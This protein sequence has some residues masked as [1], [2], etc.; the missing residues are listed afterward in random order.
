[1]K[2]RDYL[3]GIENCP[4][5]ELTNKF[6]VYDN[7]PT[8]LNADFD[9]VINYLKNSKEYN[10]TGGF[11]EESGDEL[12]RCKGVNIYKKGN[13]IFIDKK[14]QKHFFNYASGT[15]NLQVLNRIPLNS[16]NGSDEDIWNQKSDYKMMIRLH[17]YKKN[18]I[19]GISTLRA[20]AIVIGGFGKFILNENIPACMPNT[21][22]WD[23]LQDYS[24]IVYYPDKD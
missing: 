22:G 8:F 14:I 10:Y 20:L 2:L 6:G 9:S 15:V 16:C 11:T 17:P 23:N 4:D 7:W 24:R 21:L 12:I 5:E 18:K 13:L 1:M 3:K 19:K